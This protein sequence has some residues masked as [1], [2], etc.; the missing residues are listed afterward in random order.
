VYA[1]EEERF[2]AAHNFRTVEAKKLTAIERTAWQKLNEIHT[3]RIHKKVTM[4]KLNDVQIA[5]V[6]ADNSD[7][8]PDDELKAAFFADVEYVWNKAVSL[9][10]V[11]IV[12]TDFERRYGGKS[13][14]N[15]VHKLYGIAMRAKMAPL[16]EWSFESL[17]HYLYRNKI[18]LDDCG[19]RNMTGLNAA[20]KSERCWVDL[21]V[22]KHQMKTYLLESYL[23]KHDMTSDFK[24]HMR[25]VFHSHESY[26]DMVSGIEK[27]DKVDLRWQVGMKPSQLLMAKFIEETVYDIVHDSSMK[28]A[29]KS[30]RLPEEWLDY[31]GPA[32]AL[33]SITEAVA[34][35]KKTEE[36]KAKAEAAERGAIVAEGGT[37]TGATTTGD[38]PTSATE[39]TTDAEVYWKALA[40]RTVKSHV[41][42]IVEPTSEIQLANAIKSSGAVPTIVNR[43]TDFYGIIL[44]PKNLCEATT[45]P[46]T[47]LPPLRE[48]QVTKLLRG[49]LRGLTS[50]EAVDAIDMESNHL[51]HILDG[52]KPGHPM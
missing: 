16:I 18:R 34:A 15:S 50:S 33:E 12:V 39:A 14:L 46:S 35:E 28:T 42:L 25:K 36:D 45:Q 2:W 7:G 30:N 26:K 19:M 44:D 22:Y 4:G 48:E 24:A 3:Y 10:S 21:Y 38:A 6:Y 20:G 1:T 23:N 17:K 31:K 29:L 43:T 49:A 37:A 32:A 13:P 40:D 11:R 8:L 9:P 52:G 47:R 51:W 5:K 41:H 27:E